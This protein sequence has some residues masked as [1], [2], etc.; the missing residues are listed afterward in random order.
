MPEVGFGYPTVLLL[1]KRHFALDT[2]SSKDPLHVFVCAKVG[3][4]L[5]LFG[6]RRSAAGY[7]VQYEPGTRYAQCLPFL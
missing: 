2:V 7:Y 4:R 1:K 6:I 5:A 3:V